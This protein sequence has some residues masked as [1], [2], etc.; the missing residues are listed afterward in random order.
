MKIMVQAVGICLQLS[1]R[2][3]SEGL[4]EHLLMQEE[5]WFTVKRRKGITKNQSTGLWLLKAREGL[6]EPD[7]R[8]LKAVVRMARNTHE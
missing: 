1:H 3:V 7:D 8:F 5:P 4:R 2:G 6:K